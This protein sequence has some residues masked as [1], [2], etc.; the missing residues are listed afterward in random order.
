EAG[1]AQ[2][3]GHAVLALVAAV[4]DSV[5]LA[6]EAGLALVERGGVVLVGDLALAVAAD[7]ATAQ[8]LAPWLRVLLLLPRPVHHRRQRLAAL[9]PRFDRAEV[10][11]HR[12]RPRVV[13][14][15]R[16]ALARQRAGW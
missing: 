16:R 7:D 11:F 15:W 14:W 12:Y 6:A 4:E 9:L 2:V 13:V 3:F 5:E 1:D 10:H 8:V